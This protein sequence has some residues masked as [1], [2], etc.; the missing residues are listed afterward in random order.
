MYHFGRELT[1]LS[2]IHSCSRCVLSFS[3]SAAERILLEEVVVAVLVAA[4]AAA[5]VV[6]VVVVVIA[7]STNQGTHQEHF[8]H[9][10]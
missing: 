4:A 10:H 8:L 1:H 3:A 9:R 2:S 6:V 7:L 5:V